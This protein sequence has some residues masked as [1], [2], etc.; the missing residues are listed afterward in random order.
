MSDIVQITDQNYKELVVDANTPVL[1]WFWASWCGPCKMITPLME[2][3]ALRYQGGLTIGRVEA[4]KQPRICAKYGVRGLPTLIIF[5]RGRIVGGKVGAMDR[6]DLRD[7]IET[8]LP[9]P[10]QVDF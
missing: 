5:D 8:C 10:E 9:E 3:A 4:E 6:E 2:E 1:L 7:F